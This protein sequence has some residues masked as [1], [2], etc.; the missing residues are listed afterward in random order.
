M[1]SPEKETEL[2]KLDNVL[3]ARLDVLDHG[4][5][6]EAVEAGIQK[7]GKIDVL[8]NNA[9]Y[10]AYGVLEATP[11]EKIRRQFD[12]NVIGLLATTQAVLPHFRANKEGVIVNISSMGGKV[13][14]PLGSLYHGTK[15]AVEGLSEALIYELAAIGVKVKIVEPGMIKTDFGGRSLDFSNDDSMSEYQEVVGKLMTAMEPLAAAGSEPEVVAE[16]IY[17]AATDGTDQLRYTAGPD[18]EQIV[19]SRKAA[20]DATF[21]KGIKDQFGL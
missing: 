16:V 20:D 11:V 15:F 2:T 5:I 1:R 10:G 21:L 6:T 12:V 19:A 9:G 7:F 14:F 8:L 3:V 18:A 17:R 13:T 4:S